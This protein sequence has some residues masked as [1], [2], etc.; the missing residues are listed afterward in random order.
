MAMKNL[1]NQLLIRRQNNQGPTTARFNTTVKN[2]TSLLVLNWMVAN[3]EDT[4]PNGLLLDS[5][6]QHAD[7]S[8]EAAGV[9]DSRNLD[10]DFMVFTRREFE[11]LQEKWQ[12][13]RG[14]PAA[15]KQ[16][17]DETWQSF[18]TY[19]KIDLRAVKLEDF[20]E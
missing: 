8:L 17:S 16:L 14:D 4:V 15:E 1:H 10:I 9:F 5:M 18:K 3:Q 7:Q 12:A 20:V 11:A 19:Y 13:T 6:M 2:F